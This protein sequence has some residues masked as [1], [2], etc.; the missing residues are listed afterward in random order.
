MRPRGRCPQG[1]DPGACLSDAPSRNAWPPV[2]RR[3]P[4]RPPDPVAF[5]SHAVTLRPVGRWIRRARTTARRQPRT[6]RPPQAAGDAPRPPR[7]WMPPRPAPQSAGWRPGRGHGRG[8]LGRLLLRTGPRGPADLRLVVR[9]RPGHGRG[10]G[11]R[12]RRVPHAAAPGKTRPAARVLRP[13]PAPGSRAGPARQGA[14]GGAQKQHGAAQKHTGAPA[15]SPRLN[16]PPVMHPRFSA[17]L[18]TLHRG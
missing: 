6:P 4:A 18:A 1:V 17:K 2:G 9:E 5:R 10:P 8:P 7:G 3:R 12:H 13:H 15:P 16:R 11:R 14:S